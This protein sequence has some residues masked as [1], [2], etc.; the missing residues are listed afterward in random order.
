MKP[1]L[2]LGLLLTL[3]AC[4]ASSKPTRLGTSDLSPSGRFDVR[5]GDTYDDSAIYGSGSGPL[6]VLQEDAGTSDPKSR[7]R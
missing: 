1:L 6:R 5:R 3:L 2:A 4:S 7:P